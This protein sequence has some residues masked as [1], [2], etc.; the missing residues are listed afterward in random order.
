[1]KKL[2]IFVILAVLGFGCKKKDTTTEPVTPQPQRIVLFEV[3][4]NTGCIPCKEAA[5][6]IDSMMNKYPNYLRVINYH[7]KTP[8]PNDPFYNSEVDKR[9]NFYGLSGNVA[10][11]YLIFDGTVVNQGI[12][13]MDNWE[14]QFMNLAKE[15]EK[16]DINGYCEIKND[17][18]RLS[19][20][21]TGV[22]GKLFAMIIESLIDFNAPNGES[23]FD[24]VFRKYVMDTICSAG[25]SFYIEGLADTSWSYNNLSIVTFVQ[26][27]STKEI[28][29]TRE[30]SINVIQDTTQPL[31]FSL[32]TDS[33]VYE[34]RGDQF[35][36]ICEFI[37]NSQI[38]GSFYVRKI[39]NLP[40]NWFSNFCYNGSCFPPDSN[41]FK[42]EFR[43][44]GVDT[45]TLDIF[46]D[47]S[48][49]PDSGTV[50]VQLFP[51]T[52]TTLKIEKEIKVIRIP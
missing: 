16:G 17:T 7:V 43:S 45:F 41:I 42:I 48:T 36:V 20:K 8:D 19:L 6:H 5:E 35:P 29:V 50:K 31:P 1:M 51:V 12:S 4:T 49:T 52:D 34:R 11:P 44:P 23:V 22:Q 40:Q 14:T 13:N 9:L 33:L 39:N 37:V 2:K 3:F 10:T 30:L 21:V 24:Y 26:D 27:G 25:D 32:E 38:Q 46:D 28:Y 18:I 47:T 15:S